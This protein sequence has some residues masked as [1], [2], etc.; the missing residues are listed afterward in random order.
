MKNEKNKEYA[1]ATTTGE[2]L[3][4]KKRYEILSRNDKNQVLVQAS[5][6]MKY[7]FDKRNFKFS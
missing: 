4:A 7:W 6:G 3:T 2:G 5:D 1:T